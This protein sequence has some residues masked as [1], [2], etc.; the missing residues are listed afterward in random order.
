MNSDDWKKLVGGIAPALG[1]ILGGPLAGGAIQI[2]A[3]SIL[4]GSSGTPATDEA[5]LSTVLAGGI[6]PELQ[7]KLLDAENQI[8]LA[9]VAADIRTKELDVETTKSYIADVADAR[10]HNANT[11]G[12]LR[13]GY[14]VNFLSYTCV[15]ML[16]YGCYR[17]LNGVDLHAVDPGAL[18]AISTLLGGV[19]QWVMSNAGQANGFFFGSSP[20]ARANSSQLATSVSD[21][22]KAAGK[23]NAAS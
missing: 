4:G 1:T 23:K 19:V 3:N 12:I 16:L 11:V 5:K 20:T 2:L 6:T 15:F 22:A 8:K 10:A 21:T 17:V 9:V 18:V 13:L 7:A 14:I